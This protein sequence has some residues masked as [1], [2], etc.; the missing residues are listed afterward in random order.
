MGDREIELVQAAA[1]YL[2]RGLQVIALTGK[3]PNGKIHRNGIYTALV[4]RPE[5]TAD[6]ALIERAFTHTE[7]TGVGILTGW[8][9]FVIDID[10]EEGAVQWKAITGANYLPDRWVS[11]TARG[12]HLWFADTTPRSSRKLGPKLDLKS[13]GG[14][15]AAPPSQHP[16]GPIYEWLLPPG[17]EP[18]AEAPDLLTKLLDQQD[19][20]TERKLVTRL[21]NQR[22]RHKPIEDGK[23]Y[24][25][26]G[27][28]GIIKAMANAAEGERNSI[29]FWAAATM[30]EDSATEEDY[31]C[32]RDAALGAG[33][34]RQEMLATVR[35]AIK[36]IRRG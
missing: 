34:T 24:A 4:G 3:M 25:S 26:W 11:K 10:G 13:A 33:L 12:L 9:Y 14:Y 23:W 20:M 2:D 15:V 1:G 35:S 7:T 8:P 32:L 28:D 19:R 17:D 30:A 27:F 22:V 5:S 31:D 29:L 21:A 36:A 6:W 16:D 18:P